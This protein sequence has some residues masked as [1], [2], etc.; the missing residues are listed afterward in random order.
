MW[1]PM[2]SSRSPGLLHFF[3]VPQRGNFEGALVC[4]AGRGRLGSVQLSSLAFAHPFCPG[5]CLVSR[6]ANERGNLRSL[7]PSESFR[8]PLPGG[9]GR[10]PVLFLL[11]LFVCPQQLGALPGLGERL[12]QQQRG[13]VYASR[14]E[15]SVWVLAV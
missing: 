14:N 4:G 1:L 9:R 12:C 11:Y 6:V 7:T 2:D 8:A 3:G 10:W 13:L 5:C 15:V